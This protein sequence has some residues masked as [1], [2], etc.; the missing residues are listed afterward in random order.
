MLKKGRQWVMVDT[1]SQFRIRYLVEAPAAHPEYAL[2]T[3]AMEEGREFSQ[4]WLGETIVS[5]RVVSHEEALKQCREDNDYAEGFPDEK[6]CELFFTLVDD[7]ADE[8]TREQPQQQERE[9][10]D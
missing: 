7:T 5:H 4:E 3:V 9:S 6:I 8:L 2:D 10:L 1:V